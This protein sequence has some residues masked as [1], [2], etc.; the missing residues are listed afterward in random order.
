MTNTLFGANFVMEKTTRGFRSGV[1][2]FKVFADFIGIILLAL[3]YFGYTEYQQH[4]RMQLVTEPKVN[5][6]YFVD[7]HLIEPSSDAGFRYIPL[8]ISSIDDDM[9][10]FRVGN[11]GYTEKT[12]ITEHV[13]F[14]MAL[15]RI[16]FRE[17]V[18]TVSH[19]TLLNWADE[20]I[21]Y[22]IARPDNIYING[23]IVMHLNE[24]P[25]EDKVL[26]AK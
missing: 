24:L 25:E 17:N 22:D 9:Y 12:P 10:T 26:Y 5:D 15:K 21:I 4:D 18:L 20:D 8:K 7:Y 14:D 13:K 23:W 11:I 19:E 2:F 16:F 6:F 1:Q 3:L